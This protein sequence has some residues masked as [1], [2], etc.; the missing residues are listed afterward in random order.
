MRKLIWTPLVLVGLLVHVPTNAWSHGGQFKAPPGY[1]DPGQRPAED[2]TPPP[3]PPPS[4]GPPTT[5]GEDEG[6]PTGGGPTTPPPGRTPPPTTGGGSLGGPTRGRSATLSQDDWAIWYAYN[7]ASI[8]NLKEA[9]YARVSSNPLAAVVG[10]SGGN[11]DDATHDVR[12]KISSALIPAMLWALDPVNARDP[13]VESAAAIGLAK[14]TSDPLHIE[15][16]QKG[17]ESKQKLMRESAAL[18]LG[19]LRRAKP[20]DQFTGSDLDRVRETLFA[21]LG[22]AEHDV[23]TRCFAAFALG[24]LGDQP[25]GRAGAP[26]GAEHT[27]RL[28]A[29]LDREV[30]SD[31]ITVAVLTAIGLQGAGTLVDDQREVLRDL[32][33]RGRLAS[34]SAPDH[35]CAEAARALGQ[36]GVDSDVRL[37]VRALTSRRSGTLTV[38]SAAIALGRLAPLLDSEGR[39]DVA[40]E[41]INAVQKLRSGSTT[42]FA[43]VSLARIAV[44]DLQAG[45]TAVL[46]ST[47]LPKLLLGT[48]VDG[49]V[50]ERPY[51]A[52][53][54]GLIAEEIGETPRTEAE[55]DFRHDAVRVLREGAMSKRLSAHDQAA[56]A[57]ALGIARDQASV[58]LLVEVLEDRRGDAEKQG[59]AA[60]ALGLVAEGG[61]VEGRKLVRG[62]LVETHDEELKVQCATAL[63]LLRDREALPA[64]L[65]GLKEADTQSLKGQLALAIA[66][67][68]DGRAI[69]PLIQV[70][71]DRGEKDLT[72]AIVTAALGVIGD[73]EWIPSLHRITQD[74]NYLYM[75]DSCR[76]IVSIL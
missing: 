2:P 24:L 74:I 76:E 67:L 16:I 73:M 4:G 54:L 60:I 18:A 53:A 56:Y 55:G 62:L 20:E 45:S 1:V 43:L 65:M 36:V 32:V 13:D 5:G 42:G 38:A 28:F 71:Q 46:G 51:G 39:V 48:A 52:L 8:E 27:A 29:H 22:D 19:L 41:L 50:L 14:M 69:P 44:A 21:V 33:T 63:G 47:K 6:K 64:L 49:R 10:E 40:K 7:R 15:L 72:R 9:L 12:S 30:P 3:P 34:K 25:S 70:M 58:P 35:V 61:S 59:Y 31:E 23:R 57:I 66:R 11:R 75:N 17:L 68:G 26:R 37:L